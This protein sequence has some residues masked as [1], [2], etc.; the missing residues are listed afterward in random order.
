[1]TSSAVDIDTLLDQ[2][3]LSSVLKRAKARIGEAAFR[4]EL[5]KHLAATERA[6]EW[7]QVPRIANTSIDLFEDSGLQH[8]LNARGQVEH[9]MSET[10]TG[11]LFGE[12]T[13]K[14]AFA[15]MQRGIMGVVVAIVNLSGPIVYWL[16][17]FKAIPL[18]A[19]IT[20]LYII[21]I[22]MLWIAASQ[23]DL[24]IA[25][26]IIV[27]WGFLSSGFII[28][29]QSIAFFGLLSFDY[30]ATALPMLIML[31]VNALLVDS[32]PTLIRLVGAPVVVLSTLCSNSAAF[33][34]MNLN[35]FPDQIR[36]EYTV[37]TLGGL[38]PQPMTYDLITVFNSTSLALMAIQLNWLYVSWN[39]RMT[40]HLT[41]LRMP[42]LG[43]D[44]F[45]A[46]ESIP[47]WAVALRRVGVSELALAGV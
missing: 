33:V 30:R 14:W 41:T 26:Q 23:A 4:D 29:L 10:L 31:N 1:M 27:R 12:A 46:V 36:I 16:G 13:A 39:S 20:L 8:L 11:R 42:L 38:L 2:A 43:H 44:D 6:Q 3:S 19:Y 35:R 37:G 47:E 40:A 24:R 25:R 28:V 22:F 9:K 45:A 32:Y 7:E 21:A 5:T 17:L 34:I 18:V 15:W